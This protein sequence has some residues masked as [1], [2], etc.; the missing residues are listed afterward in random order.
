MT[1]VSC[2]FPGGKLPLDSQ[3]G[4]PLK[5]VDASPRQIGQVRFD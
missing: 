1:V 4:V 5:D 2:Q 3:F